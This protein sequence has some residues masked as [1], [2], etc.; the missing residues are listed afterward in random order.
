MNQ[1]LHKMGMPTLWAMTDVYGLDDMLLDMLPQ[2]VVALM[3]LFP[4]ND[5]VKLIHIWH[6]LTLKLS[7]P[8]NI[9]CWWKFGSGFN[10]KV[11][12][13]EIKLYFV[14]KIVITYCEKKMLKWLR[15]TFEFRGWRPRICKIFEMGRTIY[16]YTPRQNV[17]SLLVCMVKIEL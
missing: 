5:K 4:I 15:K 9:K 2:P 7:N 10:L 16:W 17:W 1:F 8:K 11:I 14:I 12:N 13:Y 6:L 3:L